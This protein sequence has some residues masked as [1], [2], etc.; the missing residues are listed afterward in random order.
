[1]YVVLTAWDKKFKAEIDHHKHQQFF[2][3][4]LNLLTLSTYVHDYFDL[5]SDLSP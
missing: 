3:L 5:I 2:S 4:P 1:M